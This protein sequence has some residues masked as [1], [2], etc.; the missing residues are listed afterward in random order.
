MRSR[1]F[2]YTSIRSLLTLD[3]SN[4]EEVYGGMQ[5]IQRGLEVL[6]TVSST[7]LSGR[8][9][10]INYFFD[11][12]RVTRHLNHHNNR[13]VLESLREQLEK[14]RKNH[15]AQLSKTRDMDNVPFYTEVDMVY[16]N[17]ISKLPYRVKLFGHPERLNIPAVAHK[18]RTLLLAAI[19]SAFLWKQY[20]GNVVGLFLEKQQ[21]FNQTKSLLHQLNDH[22][23]S[24][25]SK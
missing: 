5:G 9:E 3:P 20:G 10:L 7:S 13:H 2:L 21:I 12:I 25:K 23:S 6:D 4:I 14:V 16:R 17:T 19:R 8:G 18:L 24:L 15:L 22:A 1:H 11:V